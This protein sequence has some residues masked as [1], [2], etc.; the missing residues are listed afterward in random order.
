MRLSDTG[1]HVGRKGGGVGVLVG[2]LSPPVLASV[3]AATLLLHVR[4]RKRGRKRRPCGCSCCLGRP[5]RRARS[6]A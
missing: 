5:K 1:D 4:R 2:L 6:V 3:A